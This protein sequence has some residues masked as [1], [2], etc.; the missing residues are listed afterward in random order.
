[1]Y[2]NKNAYEIGYSLK[3]LIDTNILIPAEPTSPGDIE[4]QTPIIA[5]LFQLLEQG[6]HQVYIHP[7]SLD[8]LR[9]DPNPTRR[10]MREL[11]S[12]KYP[13]LPT[14][15]LISNRLQS[16]IGSALPNTHDAIDHALLATLDADAVDYLVTQDQK[17]HR[18]AQR[19]GLQ[20]RVVTA[21]EAVAVV[22]SLFP[23]KPPPPPAVSGIPAYDLNDSDPIFDSLKMDY[24]GFNEW[25]RK[26]KREHRHSWV[27]KGPDD[28]YAGICIIKPEE[29][30]VYGLQ[31]KV[32]KICTFKRSEKYP[33]FRYGEL[34][35]K[36]LLNYSQFAVPIF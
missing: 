9:G 11:L 2:N 4:S 31:G 35:L 23:V 22:R 34:I 7:A 21:S 19:A 27:I 25:L 33:G 3:F 28:S 8:E 18:K 5:E 32:L 20:T 30:G 14:I 10:D 36:A 16:I 17:L 1:M 24:L 26:C 29:S 13:R 15:P 6:N 12:A